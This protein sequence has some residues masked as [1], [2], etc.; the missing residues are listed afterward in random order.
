[1]SSALSAEIIT[2]ERQLVA[3]ADDWFS[4]WRGSPTASPFQSPAWLIPWWRR[5]H[6]GELASIAVRSDERLVGLA[7]FYLEDGACSRRLLPLGISVSDYLDLLIAPDFAEAA[8]EAIV[9][10]ALRMAAP[11]QK[12]ELEELPPQA[13][14]RNIACPAGCVERRTDQSICPVL[15]LPD[16]ADRLRGCLSQSKRRHLQ[17]ARNRAARMGGLGIRRVSG[18]EI[19][20]FLDELERLHRAR[21][22]SRGEAGVMADER[23]LPFHREAAVGLDRAGA[24]RFYL[25]LNR[26]VPVAALY[27][28]ADRHRQLGYL[29]GFDPEHEY[30]NPG[31]LLLL[32]AIE[33][34][35]TEG[36]LEFHFLRGREAYK[37]GWNPVER[38]NI[39]RS[40]LRDG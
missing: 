38:V 20:A 4:L 33:T 16:G 40:F 25:A 9:A 24:A 3:L 12:W 32:H 6:P 30:E 27:L 19:P 35:I 13:V 15:P 10:A 22:E 37:Y 17:L 11:W 36:A 5:F 14:A 7:A 21:W 28:L 2:G 1:M 29:S 34:A 8:G 23:I 18:D 31:S 26:G 39:K